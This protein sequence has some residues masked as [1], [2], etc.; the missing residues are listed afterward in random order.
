MASGKR[1]SGQVIWR[2]W[3]R[4]PAPNLHRDDGAAN[5]SGSDVARHFRE[6]AP[7]GNLLTTLY[8]GPYTFA[9]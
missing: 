2:S 9:R 6:V 8:S 5:L 1:S 4:R 3:P 7:L